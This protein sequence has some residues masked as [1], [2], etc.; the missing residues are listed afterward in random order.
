M[1]PK[2][3]LWGPVLGLLTALSGIAVSAPDVAP[4]SDEETRKAVTA[5]KQAI[6]A[7]HKA[8]DRA[9]LDKLYAVDYT[10]TDAKGKVTTK[11]E[12]LDGLATGPEIV[13]GKYEIL[14]VRR[15][16][17]IAV[18]PGHGRLV[19]RNPDGSTGVSEYDS[20]NV[21]ELVDGR[22]YYAAAYLP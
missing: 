15:W 22:W 4:S 8:R 7:G 6:V 12:L 11:K 5:V 9:A 20:V 16:G 10:A 1:S 19:Y 13:E 18:A 21:F 2:P 14:S 17:N 3:S